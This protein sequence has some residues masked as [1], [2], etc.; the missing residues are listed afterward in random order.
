MVD[1]VIIGAGVS[2]CA[3]AREISRYKADV[4]VLEREEDVCCGTTKANSAIEI[5]RASCRERV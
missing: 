5:G 3:I 4:L 2:G 1:I